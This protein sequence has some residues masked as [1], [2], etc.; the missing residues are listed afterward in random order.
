M[1][2]ARAYTFFALLV[3]LVAFGAERALT[4][5]DD[6][7]AANR[8]ANAILEAWASSAENHT[9]RT[10][11]TTDL[12]FAIVWDHVRSVG[13]VREAG[14]DPKT[15]Q[16]LSD[17]ARQT[18]GG[19]LMLVDDAGTLVAQSAPPAAPRADLGDHDW[20]R[21]HQAR[22]IDRYVGPSFYSRITNEIR[23]TYSRSV[24]DENGRFMGALQSSIKQ[25]FFAGVPISIAMQS[26]AEIAV[27]GL[28]GNLVA[29]STMTQERLQTGFVSPEIREAVQRAGSGLLQ[30]AGF[31][32]R[33]RTAFHVLP[34]WG[35]AVTASIP[36]AD[37]LSPWRTDRRNAIITAG[38][39]ATVLC[40]LGGFAFLSAARETRLTQQLREKTAALEDATAARDLLIREV[41]HRVNNNLQV[42]SSLLRI[43]ARRTKDVKTLVTTTQDRIQ[44]MAAMH[45]VIYMGEISEHVDLDAYLASLVNSVESANAL[46]SWGVRIEIDCDPVTVTMDRMTPVGLIIVEV[47]SN[48]A[49]HGFSG[50]RYGRLCITARRAAGQVRIEIR[51][52]GAPLESTIRPSWGGRLIDALAGQING[53]HQL[54][55][56]GDWTVFRLT[57]DDAPAIGPPEGMTL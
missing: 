47:L 21:A 46:R 19:D 53:E 8:S 51:N 40:V 5:R 2:K 4:L 20:F 41:H 50:A 42:V 32:T 7:N 11:E 23:F 49:E 38:V 1:G 15:H 36:E 48:A 31:D 17:L 37:V 26:A 45:E 22:K 34:E 52:D 55:R 25:S 33:R 9:R 54:I 27:W 3:A 57:F 35:V 29:A 14:D 44:V 10:L 12:I 16:L 43:N 24:T 13:G 6:H 30:M 28:D 18:I 56:E 39:L